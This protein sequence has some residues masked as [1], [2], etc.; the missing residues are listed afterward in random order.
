MDK[1]SK[2]KVALSMLDL[3]LLQMPWWQLK[4]M[5]KLQIMVTAPTITL[6]GR[7]V[8]MVARA[9]MVTKEIPKPAVRLLRS[10][11]CSKK[12]AWRITL[13]AASFLLRVK[14]S[15]EIVGC[16]RGKQRQQ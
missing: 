5:W 6:P 15:L 7:L 2:G 11:R 9:T 14:W 1:E 10:R 13:R 16:Q 8:T 12:V 4:P 3:S